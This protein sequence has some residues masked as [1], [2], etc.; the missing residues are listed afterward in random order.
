[1][2]HALFALG[3]LAAL[4]G[5]TGGNTANREDTQPVFTQ[6]FSAGRQA[7]SI[8]NARRESR[9]PLTR[10]ALDTVGKSALE[11]TLERSGI[12]AYLFIDTVRQD[13]HPGQITVWRTEDNITLSLRSGV[14]VATRGLGGDVLSTEVSLAQNRP[15]PTATSPRALHV[16]SGN[17]KAT[18]FDLDCEIV[19]LGPD[20]VAIVEIVYPTRHL[21]ERCSAAQGGQV[22]NDYWVDARSDIIWQSRQWAGPQIGYI[23][24]RRL[25]E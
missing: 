22:V 15:G 10:A 3:L 24:F 7:I 25:I 4:S 6:L 23:A 13:V 16:R 8:R 14:L 12:F 18:R 5:C 1:M 20:P 9:P 2:K 19:D 21:Q 17:A 11:A